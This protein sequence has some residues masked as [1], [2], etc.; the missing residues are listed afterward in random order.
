MDA[1][2]AS[3]FEPSSSVDWHSDR[4]RCPGPFRWLKGNC[5]PPSQVTS[6][7]VHHPLYPTLPFALP[8]TRPYF[9]FQVVLL[10]RLARRWPASIS[11]A[12]RPSP[13]LLAHRTAER[14]TA[15]HSTASTAQAQAQRSRRSCWLG[16]ARS[17]IRV[18]CDTCHA[19]GFGHPY[20]PTA[21]IP[22]ASFSGCRL[23]VCFGFAFVTR[24]LRALSMPAL[25]CSVGRA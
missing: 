3:R 13:S 8:C 20:I 11:Q 6:H 1:P 22:S 9:P 16:A 19:F 5:Q 15:Q 12:D 25:F 17:I 4:D 24:P 14:S 7:S 21:W 23:P 10:Q 2:L 18:S